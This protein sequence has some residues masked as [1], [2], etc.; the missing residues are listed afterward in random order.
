MASKIDSRPRI[1]LL[2]GWGRFPAVVADA[3]R[4]Q[5][6]EVYCLG[7]R[8][9]AEMEMLRH[10]V[11]HLAPVGLAQLGRAIRHFRKHGI[12]CATM[13]GKIH[14]VQ[15][16]R[17]FAFWHSLPDWR[18]VRVFWPHFVSRTK[19]CRDD[20][21]LGAVIN[22]YSED[23]IMFA[24]P[25]DFAPE[26]LVKPGQIG[27]PP[28][29]LSQRKD[30]EFGWRVAKELGRLD[31]GQSVAVRGQTVIAVEAIEGTDECIRRAGLLC[32]QGN[33]VMVKVSK[34]QQ[35]MRF[36]VPTIGLLTLENLYAAGGRVLA[37][38]AGRTIVVDQESVRKFADTHGISL[39]AVDAHSYD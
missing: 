30:I 13:A 14:K 27:G 31:I 18:A 24:P 25:T 15:L 9:N 37:I 38:E 11:D 3:L 2:A 33:F 5:G 32:Q 6:Y 29:S 12:T 1:G 28:V 26:L 39:V 4:A 8:G 7:V 34:P 16:F 22:A 21:L 10:H 19:D 35:D 17:K 36:D 20:S 23:G